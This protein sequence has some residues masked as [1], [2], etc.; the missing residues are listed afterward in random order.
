MQSPSIVI[1]VVIEQHAEAAAFHWLLRD[2]A[3]CAPHYSLDDLVKLDNR[4]D[5]HLDELRI[6]AGCIA[7]ELG[8]R[9][10][11]G[12]DG[13]IAGGGTVGERE[14]EAAGVVENGRIFRR[15]R[16]HKRHRAIVGETRRER[17]IVDNA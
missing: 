12:R 9:E 6:A 5:A 16:V 1:P 17:R 15:T 7:G 13:R 10:R 11:I 4:L 2:V 8:Q 14:R 3:V